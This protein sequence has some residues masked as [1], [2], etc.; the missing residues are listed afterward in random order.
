MKNP[1]AVNKKKDI[2]VNAETDERLLKN[3]T[4][5]SSN[6]LPFILHGHCVTN[7]SKLTILKY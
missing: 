5:L 3:N 6:V 1:S 7:V 2:M 4:K